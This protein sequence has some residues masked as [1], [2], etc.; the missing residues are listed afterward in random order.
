MRPKARIGIRIRYKDYIQDLSGTRIKY[1][2]QVHTR[3]WTDL[4]GPLRDENSQ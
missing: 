4:H 3:I 2:D 1:K